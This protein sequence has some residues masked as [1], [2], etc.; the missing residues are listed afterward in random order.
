MKF[1]GSHSYFK[2]KGSGKISLS[3]VN[4]KFPH[5]AKTGV[6]WIVTHGSPILVEPGI[7]GEIFSIELEELGGSTYRYCVDF[8]EAMWLSI[9]FNLKFKASFDKTVN[10]IVFDA[11][12]RY[13]ILGKDK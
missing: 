8:I 1:L 13:T 11:G 2:D 9:T 3:D 7:H 10:Y 4:S 6:C 5:T 12:K